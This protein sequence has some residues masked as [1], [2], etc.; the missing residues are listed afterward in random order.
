MIIGAITLLAMLFGGGVELL[1]ISNMDKGVK[2][3]VVEKERKKEILADLKDSR[4]FIKAY[5]KQR[6]SQLKTFKSLNS[7]WEVSKEDLQVFFDDL[8][9]ERIAFQDKVFVDRIMLTKKIEPTEWDS[10][11]GYAGAKFEKLIEKEQKKAD[12]KK[13]KKAKE[14]FEKTRSAIIQNVPDV[15]KQKVLEEGLNDLTSAFEEL[16]N[17]MKSINV[18][19]SSILTRQDATKEELKQMAEE[20][21]ELR[22]KSSDQLMK[23]H[24]L[25]KENTNKTEWDKIMKA[26]NKELTLT[27]H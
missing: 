18:K 2:E 3:Y 10:I 17:T 26:F 5:N 15:E 27:A 8:Y 14:S 20:S 9:K 13:N 25:A 21:N 22:R 23:F 4:K 19:E 12:K 16:V 24:M 11:M 7:S 6:K 1:F